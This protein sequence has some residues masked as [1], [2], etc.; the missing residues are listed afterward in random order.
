L[1]GVHRAPEGLVGRR[2]FES[3]SRTLSV[4][5]RSRKAQFHL[6]ADVRPTPDGQCPA[7]QFGALAHAG[8]T[9]VAC[10]AA[11][12]KHRRLDALAI[13]AHPQSKLTHVV[14]DLDFD[15]RGASVLKRVPQ[16]LAGNPVHLVAHE[17][18][19]ITRR[20]FDANAEMGRR[21]RRAFRCRE[22]VAER[23]HD[24]REIVV[25]NRLRA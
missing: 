12:G 3:L 11:V 22:L 13:V 20:P 24:F 21:L 1:T 6:G 23:A 4:R 8:Q 14:A 18:G 5:D 16:R 10:A 15:S 17:R 25:G 19:E 7:K 2:S 9:V